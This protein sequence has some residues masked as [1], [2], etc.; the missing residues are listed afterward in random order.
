MPTR[1]PA[2]LGSAGGQGTARHRGAG[3]PGAAAQPAPPAR[4]GSRRG[5]PGRRDRRR[6]VALTARDLADQQAAEAA[7]Q[8]RVADAR[9]LGAEALRSDELDRS[10]LLAAAGV[11]LDDSADTRTNLLATLDR[12]PALVG[13]ARS[14]GR[15]LHQAVN[16]SPTRWRSWPPTASDSSSTTDRPCAASPSRRS[17]SAEQSSRD[18]TVRGTQCRSRATSSRWGSRRSGCWTGPGRGQRSSSAASRRGTTPSTWASLAAGTSGYSPTSRWFTATMVHLQEEQPAHTFVWD[19]RSPGGRLAVLSLAEMGSAATISPDGRTLYTA[20]FDEALA[21]RGGAL[22]VT[23]VPSG[24]TRRTLTATDLGCHRHRRR[25]GPEPG[26]PDPR[27]RRRRRGR[28]G[29]HRH[30]DAP[31]PPLRTG[32]DP[33][34]RLLAGRHPPGG[35]RRTADGV[36][37]RWATSPWRFWP[38]DGVVDD[39]GF[40]GDGRTIYTKTTAG[41]V[42]AWD[43]AGDRRFLATQRGEHLDMPDPFAKISPDG[44]KVGY[45]G[46]GP[47]SG[48]ATS[49]REARPG[50]HP[51]DGPRGL[52]RHRLAPRQHHPQR[53]LW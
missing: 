43:L 39:P 47:G 11:S 19:L 10:L 3:A 8:A 52:Q 1:L 26:R 42:Q 35:D 46:V 9:R 6:G 30:A 36:G 45:V 29:G 53:H 17:S 50:D 24:T 16:R 5:P 7:R 38:V 14:A 23:D 33:G 4:A 21:P 27:G 28:P 49:P 12:A 41:L 34:P 18:R 37:P 25:P 15:I 13:S 51:R 20:P 2:R 40:S 22:L 44:S 31:S 32:C 48:S